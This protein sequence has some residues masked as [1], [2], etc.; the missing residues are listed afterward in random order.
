MFA[1]VASAARPDGS[2]PKTLESAMT[3]LAGILALSGS[4][5]S[6]LLDAVDEG[7]RQYSTAIVL[8]TSVQREGGI[9]TIQMNDLTQA[10]AAY[11]R[12]QESIARILGPE[13]SGYYSDLGAKQSV[14]E[15]FNRWGMDGQSL[16][17]WRETP[18][19]GAQRELIMYSHVRPALPGGGTGGARLG[20]QDR[21]NLRV[22][23]GPLEGLI[24]A[25]F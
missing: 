10:K 1:N 23:I 13:R 16:M 6:A 7:V 19:R 9:V 14:L 20:V 8:G 24:P 12:M 3:Q 5:T 2:G 17:V 21:D 25:D 4:E 22:N 18:A 11:E 15:C